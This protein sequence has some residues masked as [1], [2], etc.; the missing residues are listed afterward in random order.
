M[1]VAN[2]PTIQDYEDALRA[3]VD[4]L[5]IMYQH[6]GGEAAKKTVVQLLVNIN[7]LSPW[8][9]DMAKQYPEFKQLLEELKEKGNRNG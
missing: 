4:Q 8:L 1:G 5:Y 3:S 9:E 7:R 2:Q 6:N